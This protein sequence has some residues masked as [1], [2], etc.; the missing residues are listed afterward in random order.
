MT[1][2]RYDTPAKGTA[3]WHLPL[4]GN[5]DKLDRDVEVRDAESN[6]DTYDPKAGSKFL[7]TDTGAVYIGDSSQWN[8][9]GGLSS[10]PEGGLG[11]NLNRGYVVPVAKGLDVTDVVDP[12]STSSPVQDAIDKI[13]AANTSGVVY[14]PPGTTSEP[15]PI[16]IPHEARGINIQGTGFSTDRPG[17]CV[18]Q[19]TGDNP[20]F[21]V[22]GWGWK[23][24]S[25][26]GFTLMGSGQSYPALHFNG[27]ANPRMFHIGSLRFSRWNDETRGVMWYD[28]AS[29][30]SCRFETLMFEATAGPCINFDN[31]DPL[32]VKIDNMYP[33]GSTQDP[34][35]K[36]NT[37]SPSIVID[38][39]NVGG[40]HNR[41]LDFATM[42]Q[43]GYVQVNFINYEPNLVSSIKTVCKLGGRGYTYLPQIV[44]NGFSDLNQVDQVVDLAWANGNNIIGQIGN[45]GNVDIRNNLINVTRKPE[46]PSWYFGPSSDIQNSA[47]TSTGLVRSLASAGTGN[48]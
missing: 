14:L 19:I 23:F 38:L 34:V 28:D 4:N 24:A 5:F 40:A 13:A 42:T 20:G 25:L 12:S 37:Q 26:D 9:L 45:N 21:D 6:R 18:L 27:S 10:S 41:V 43:N 48:A 46:Y 11:K 15:G 33:N 36:C 3:D 8:Y 7:A 35:I 22:S 44:V 31:K 39:C 2:N 47:G 29:P 1:N 30:F 16:T 32:A 17:N